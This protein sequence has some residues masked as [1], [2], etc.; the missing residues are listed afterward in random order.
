MDELLMFNNVSAYSLKLMRYIDNMIS[1]GAISFEKV[2]EILEN[3][4]ELRKINPD[5][6]EDT[7]SVYRIIE[8]I[9]VFKS[10]PRDK[11]SKA[12]DLEMLCHQSFTQI[13]NIIDEKWIKHSCEEIGCKER[14]IVI[15][16]NEKLY[17][18]V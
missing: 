14:F 13:K 12:L 2:G 1:I 10:W 16:G 3:N 15:D 5:R 18:Y 17:R 11:K 8:F 7:W 6:T 4:W 9:K